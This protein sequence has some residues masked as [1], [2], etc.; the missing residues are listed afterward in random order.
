MCIADPLS[1]IGATL[2]YT[3]PLKKYAI[4]TGG[5][6]FDRLN[7]PLYFSCIHHVMLTC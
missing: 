2:L 6:A 1:P 4:D 7:Q 3:I 5:F